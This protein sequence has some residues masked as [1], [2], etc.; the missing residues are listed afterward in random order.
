[1][2]NIRTNERGCVVTKRRRD[3]EAHTHSKAKPFWLN[4]KTRSESRACFRHR[5]PHLTC[6][7]THTHVHMHFKCFI[8]AGKNWECSEKNQVS[9]YTVH[10]SEENIYMGKNKFAECIYIYILLENQKS[11]VRSR[12]GDILRI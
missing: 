5:L 12:K 11:K 6:M 4:R 1:M 8:N 9:F 2:G 7:L 10:E 3:T